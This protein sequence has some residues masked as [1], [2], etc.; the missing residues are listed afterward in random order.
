[1]AKIT[2][3]GAHP[4]DI[5]LSCGGTI[6]KMIRLGHQVDCIVLSASQ[7]LKE[8]K[9][10]KEELKKSMLFL[11][12]NIK[13][14]NFETRYFCDNIPAIR[15]FLFKIDADIIYTHSPDSNHT[16]HRILFECVKSIFTDKTIFCF[17]DIT[18]QINVNYWELLFPIDI[19]NKIKVLNFY[20]SQKDRPYFNNDRILNLAVMRGQQMNRE[21]AEAFQ[22]FRMVK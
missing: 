8:N 17:E 5:E 4:D 7:H 19:K 16:D 15:D 2:F 13:L 21:L 14:G 1:M 3:I 10:I 6:S 22:I 20:K 9:Q 18:S 12:A 11:E